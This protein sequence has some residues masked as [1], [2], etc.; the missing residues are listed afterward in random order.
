MH[1][2]HVLAAALA[3]GVALGAPGVARADEA[4]AAAPPTAIGAKI[5]AFRTT[6][7]DGHA[8]DSAA[9]QVTPAAVEAQVRQAATAVGAAADAPWTTTLESLPGLQDDEGAVDADK[10]AAFV[11]AAGSHFGRVA[12]EDQA[13]AMT[14]LADV[15][16]WVAAAADQPIIYIAWSPKCPTSK[17]LNERMLELFAK[18]NARVFALLVNKGDDVATVRLFQERYGFPVRV[19]LDP[20]FAIGGSLGAE[21]TPH[22]ILADKGHVLRYRGAMDNDL[23][24][25]EGE[26]RKDYL[27][28]AIEA[29]RS[30]KPVAETTTEPFG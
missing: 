24:D 28:D 11:A 29:V 8:F 1:R 18:A 6:D 16:A 12:N 17:K 9:L 4:E 5:P 13:A 23:H 26:N 15:R 3:L 14:T 21:R 20:D 25:V 10:L 22:F 19:L 27:A 30:G 2:L 7:I